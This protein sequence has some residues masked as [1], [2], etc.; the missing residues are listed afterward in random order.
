MTVV[1]VNWHYQDLTK[2]KANIII[3]SDVTSHHDIAEQ[4]LFG[5]KQQSLMTGVISRAGTT[6]PSIRPEFILIFL[7]G[8]CCS[9][10]PIVFCVVLCIIWFVLLSSFAIILFILLRFMALD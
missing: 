6:Y 9:I 3:S 10:Q 7:W 2:Y 8:S 1:L 4:L 5:V